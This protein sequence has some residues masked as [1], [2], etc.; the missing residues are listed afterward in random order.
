[1]RANAASIPASSGR[2]A[3]ASVIGTGQYGRVSTASGGKLH[4]DLSLE[5]LESELDGMFARSNAS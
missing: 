2:I 4:H 3:V 1:V 5:Q